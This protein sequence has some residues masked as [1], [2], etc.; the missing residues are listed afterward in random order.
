MNRFYLRALLGLIVL[1][2]LALVACGAPAAPTQP[3]AAPTQAAAAPTQPPAAPT[4]AAPSQPS[5][6]V[7]LSYF[8]RNNDPQ[9]W[10]EF[11][12]DVAQFN[13]QH[14]GK[15]HVTL[16]GIDGNTFRTKAPIELRSSNP[17]DIFFSWEGG[18]AQKMV[19]S[20]FALPLD[21]YYAKYGWDKFLNKAGVAL[22]NLKGHKYFV[23][24]QM[25][26]SYVWYRTDIF[27]KYNIAVPKT[28]DDYMAACE[29]LKKNGVSCIMEGNQQKWPGQ[30][31][32]SGYYVNK[33]GLDQYNK[34]LAHQIPWTDASVVDAFQTMRDLATK[35]YLFPGWNSIDQGPALIPFSQGK[36]A[37]WYQ[38][39]WQ[40]NAFKGDNKDIPY[41][42]DFFPYPTVGSQKPTVE[43]FVENTLMIN[44]KTPHKDE[45]AQFLDW[46][47][48]KE[49]QQHKTDSQLPYAANTTVDLSK[50]LPLAQKAGAAMANANEFTFM[51][52][53]HALD[54]AI[55][56]VFLT[57]LQGVFDGTITPAA[58]AKATEDEVNKVAAG[59]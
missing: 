49:A 24:T 11:N 2:S 30:F 25:S 29:T 35:G 39:T 32:W 16:S 57:Q 50:L 48:S 40:I 42:V 45:A 26:A 1:A 22:A 6:V 27:Q 20:G 41:P 23:P 53:D 38:G 7:E 17:P 18:W 44:A 58:A 10:A 56:D 36:V 19:D 28:F 34:L 46:V 55:A 37:T 51:H 59:Q 3:P 12:W 47:I 9:D 5:G 15:I 31:D 21:D 33:Y 4:S 52:P 43:I 8:E 14:T 13:Q 54:P